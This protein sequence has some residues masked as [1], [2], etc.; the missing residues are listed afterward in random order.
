MMKIAFR[1]DSSLRIGTGHMMRCMALADILQSLGAETRFICRNILDHHA[2]LLQRKN[3][4]VTQLPEH[5]RPVLNDG[6]AHSEWLGVSQWQDAEDSQRA[7]A[8][9]FWD[10]LVVDH[11]ALDFR[12]EAIM[13]Y[14][15]AHI[16]VIDDL[17]D[18]KHTCHVLLD[19][20]LHIDME[21]RYSDNV[22]LDC[23]LFLGP[24]YALLREEFLLWRNFV[25]PRTGPVNQVL[26][27]L[28]GVDAD[29]ITSR[30]IRAVAKLGQPQIRV[31]VVVG[32]HHPARDCIE[33][34]C[35]QNGYQF[36]VETRQ[37]AEM[38]AKSDVAIGSAGTSTWE[39]CCLG[40][41]TLC[42]S[43]AKN[44]IPIAKALA[45]HE[46]GIDLGEGDL[47]SEPELQASLL[48]LIHNRTELTAFSNRCL[49]LV[50]G[51]GAKRVAEAMRS[52]G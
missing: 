33:T 31:A 40:L 28:G 51:C 21:T 25:R 14:S 39:R 52:V 27:F 45:L 23:R 17:A 1:T 4:S 43:I 42:V 6:L 32:A 37:M 12:W 15:A 29:N 16:L 35:R 5:R 50:D 24:D 18:R 26:V 44:Q 2:A 3:H 8:D 20:N 36:Y 9:E 22:P 46:A 41:P 34:Y 48:R 47:L 13:Q 19:Q 10:W 7:L 38:M 49:S 11:Y 30:V